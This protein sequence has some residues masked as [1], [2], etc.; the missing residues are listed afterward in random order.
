MRITPAGTYLGAVVEDFQLD[1]T[2]PGLGDMLQQLLNTYKVVMFR[3]QFLT[4]ETHRAVAA[5]IG[6]T[7]VHPFGS[8]NDPVVQGITPHAPHPGLPEVSAIHH[9]AQ[10]TGNLNAWHSDL[11]WREKPTYVSVLTAR[12]LPPLGG[13][14]IFAD[15]SNA[16]LTLPE[17]LR[18]ELAGLKVEHDWMRIYQKSFAANPDLLADLRER[19][20]TQQHPLVL[21]HPVTKAPVLFSNKV[22]GERIIGTTVER[23]R[24]LLELVHRRASLP[25]FQARF[26]WGVGDVAMWDNL[27][28]QHYAVSDYAPH[29]RLMERVTVSSRDIW[30]A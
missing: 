29:E 1:P 25:E 14:T 16:Y 9:T 10:H 18:R 30:A 7:E 15:M 4:P 5:T 20:P 17:E 8:E 22:S 3:R 13:D 28:V 26:S 12:K 21:T 19:Y 11:N 27:A 2:N 6:P 24:E 23:G